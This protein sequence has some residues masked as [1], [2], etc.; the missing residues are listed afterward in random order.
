M[1]GLNKFLDFAFPNNGVKGRY[2]THFGSTT[3][4]NGSVGK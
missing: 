2:Y 1:E 3:L 4:T